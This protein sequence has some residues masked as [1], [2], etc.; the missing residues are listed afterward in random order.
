MKRSLT[1]SL[2]ILGGVI[3]AIFVI[4]YLWAAGVRDNAVGKQ[5]TVNEG[6]ANVQ[7]AYQRR[8]DLVPN[9]VNT[10]KGAAENEKQ[11]LIEVTKARA[12]IGTAKT[13]GE[14]EAHGATINRAIAIVFERYPEVKATQNFAMLQS[15]LESTENGVRTERN[16]YNETVKEYN[17]YI[18]G[19]FKRMALRMIADEEDNLIKRDPFEAK[20]E[21]QDAPTVDFSDINKKPA[22]ADSTGK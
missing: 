8:A 9:L 20:E 12:G 7:A 17:T 4:F 13:P 19:T 3:V 6:W 5:E 16:R 18:R 10:V 21:S 22:A 15:Q 14:L 2:L 11:I 1:T